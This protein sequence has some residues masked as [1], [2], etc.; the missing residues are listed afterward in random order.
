MIDFFKRIQ[1]FAGLPDKD[2][3]QLADMVTEVSLPARENLFVEGDLGEEA[4][5]IHTGE[6]EIRKNYGQSSILI[7]VRHEGDII[8][9]MALLDA[10]H[11]MADAYARVDSV[12][13]SLNQS[14]FDQLLVSSPTAARVTLRTIIPR[15]RETESILQTVNLRLQQEIEERRQAENSLKVAHGELQA[16]TV[17][18]TD[19]LNHLQATQQELIQTGK[20]AVLGQLVAGVAHEINTPFGCDSSIRK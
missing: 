15:W 2:L 12:V 9:E 18:L 14:Q 20:M 3:E 1:F 11:R 19:T 17:E 16:R 5:I 7:A 4:Y 6:I 8:G 13:Y 10:S